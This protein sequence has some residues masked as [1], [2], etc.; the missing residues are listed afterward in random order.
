MQVAYLSVQTQTKDKDFTGKSPMSLGCV[1]LEEFIP[2][3][4]GEDKDPIVYRKEEVKRLI[5]TLRNSNLVITFGTYCF[6]VLEKY[7]PSDSPMH[8][9][10]SILDLQEY[11]SGQL[12]T[13]VYLDTLGRAWNLPRLVKNGLS[14]IAL[15]E[16]GKLTE[17]IKSLSRDIEIMKVSFDRFMTS[18]YV[19]LVD[20]RFDEMVHVSAKR[21]PGLAYELQSKSFIE[22]CDEYLEHITKSHKEGTNVALDSIPQSEAKYLLSNNRVKVVRQVAGIPVL[23]PYDYITKQPDF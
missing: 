22:K 4:G 16:Q 23:K 18:E 17:M 20:P 3:G 7:Y 10:F 14:Y 21:F 15:Y 9:D 12:E 6:D 11:I 5:D 2:F 19:D 13:R 8:F 1:L